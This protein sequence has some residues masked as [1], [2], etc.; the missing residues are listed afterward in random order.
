MRVIS[1][2]ALVAFWERLPDAKGPLSAWYDT[3]SSRTWK[4]LT[5]LRQ[6]SRT[7]DYV[8][9]DRFVFN[10]AGNNFR[11]VVRIDFNSQ[12]AFVRFVGTHKEYDKIDKISEI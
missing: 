11:L 8:G 9:G 5:E 2:K 12:L 10:I 3:I 6:L 7:V 1:R 4:N